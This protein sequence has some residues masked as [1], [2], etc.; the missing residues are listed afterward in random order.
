M[1]NKVFVVYNTLSKRYGDVVAYPTDE[2]A[3]ARL[4]PVLSR[5]G[6]LDEFELCRV[7]SVDV[8]TGV[9][10]PCPPVRIAWK[11]LALN[12]VAARSVDGGIQ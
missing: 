6:S 7:G 5:Q 8:E 1:E 12:E 4:Q 3:L 2:F 10:S 11:D 9:I